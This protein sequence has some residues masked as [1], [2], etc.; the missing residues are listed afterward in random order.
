LCGDLAELGF[1]IL[2]NLVPIE[3]D[4]G[5]DHGVMDGLGI[6]GD[7]GE[8]VVDTKTRME[9]GFFY[10]PL[11]PEVSLSGELIRFLRIRS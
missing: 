11:S 2:S 3:N 5:Q 7:K 1:E 6:A 9:S 10:N 8:A 4:V